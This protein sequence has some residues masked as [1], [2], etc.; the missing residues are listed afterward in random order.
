L[1]KSVWPLFPF[2]AASFV[3]PSLSP[4]FPYSDIKIVKKLAKGDVEKGLEM[5][6][7]CQIE[8]RQKNDA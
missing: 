7:N 5:V 2:P 6:G 3:I 8:G 1:L 4:P